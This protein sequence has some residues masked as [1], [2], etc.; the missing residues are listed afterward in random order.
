MYTRA[1]CTPT[2]VHTHTC[3]HTHAHTHTCTHT[4]AHS[5]DTPL[6]HKEREVVNTH[7]TSP[8]AILALGLMYL[9]TNDRLGRG[10]IVTVVFASLLITIP[11]TTLSSPSLLS[12]PLLPLP[13]LF[14][15][16]FLT[17]PSLLLSLRICTFSNIAAKLDVPATQFGLD[18]VRPDFLLLRVR[19]SVFH[20]SVFP[21][22]FHPSVFP[23]VFHP[24]VFLSVPPF[25]VPLSVPP[26]CVSLSVPP[27]CVPLSVPPFC[28]PLSVPLSVP[29]FCV[30]LSVPPFCV[31]L[32]SVVQTPYSLPGPESWAGHV[33]SCDAYPGVDSR[34]YPSLHFG[35]CVR[36]RWWYRYDTRT[37]LPVI[38]VGN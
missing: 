35:E 29:P 37:G 19:S 36:R 21:S 3:T 11:L 6:H 17:A 5:H 14:L 38:E 16:P 28:V 15:L 13:L 27:F 32:S 24:S 7:V 9:K 20:P 10:Y 12:L 4:H 2:H 25:C 22:V 30:P 23:S 33:G 18:F 34:T 26:F 8:G 31:P 1:T